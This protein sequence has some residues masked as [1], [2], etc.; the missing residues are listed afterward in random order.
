MAWTDTEMAALILQKLEILRS[1][2]TP[3]SADQTLTLDVYASRMEYLRDDELV[4]YADNAVPDALADPLAEYMMFFVSSV[5]GVSQQE[6]A[7]YKQ[8]SDLGKIDLQ[9]NAAKRSQGAAVQ[10][11]YF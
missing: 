3:T 4:W 6:R 8:R 11:D 1:G 9:R 2:E 5:F 10:A 7:E